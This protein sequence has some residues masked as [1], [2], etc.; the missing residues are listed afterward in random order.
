MMVSGVVSAVAVTEDLVVH[1]DRGESITSWGGG[2]EVINTGPQWPIHKGGAVI[3]ILPWPGS[4]G[5]PCGWV[6]C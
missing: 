3:N 2:G 1:T 5:S 6:A 4:W